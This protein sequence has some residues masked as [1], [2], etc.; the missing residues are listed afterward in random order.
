VTDL[1]P[2][3]RR[4]IRLLYVIAIVIVVDQATELLTLIWPFRPGL[5]SWRFGMLG[6]AMAKLEFLALGDAAALAAAFLLG[7]RKVLLT[8]AG[9]HLLFALAVGTAMGMLVLD[10]L[11]LRTAVRP[12]AAQAFDMTALRTL[13]TSLMAL[14]ASLTVAVLLW[15]GRGERPRPEGR[16]EGFLVRAGGVARETSE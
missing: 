14:L 2:P 6:L 9:L 15:R 13:V 11:Q 5:A 16:D 12:E 7:H 1:A 4:L 8:L 10:T 3:A